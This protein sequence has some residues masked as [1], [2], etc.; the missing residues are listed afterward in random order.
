M[1]V[2][3]PVL[4]RARDVTELTQLSQ[5]I[6]AGGPRELSKAEDRSQMRSVTS[7]TWL[8]PPATV[9]RVPSD[10]RCGTCLNLEQDGKDVRPCLPLF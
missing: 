9:E 3:K 10:M 5:F 4:D 6:L 7:Y 8:T 1:H 2:K